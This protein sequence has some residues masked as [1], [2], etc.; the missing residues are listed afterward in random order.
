[1]ISHLYVID[2]KNSGRVQNNEFTTN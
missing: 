1:M 2:N